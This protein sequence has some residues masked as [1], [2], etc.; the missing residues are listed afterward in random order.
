MVGYPVVKLLLPEA[1]ATASQGGLADSDA[2]RRGGGGAKLA[3]LEYKGRRTYPELL[4]WAK[5]HAKTESVADADA[6]D[7]GKEL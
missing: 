3:S 2:G 1:A 5:A 4:A 7:K 6:A